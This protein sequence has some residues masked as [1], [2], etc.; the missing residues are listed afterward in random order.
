MST[1]TITIET[2]LPSHVLQL[3]ESNGARQACWDNLKVSKGLELLEESVF[4]LASAVRQPAAVN[5]SDLIFEN[6]R[7]QVN[8]RRI[9]TASGGGAV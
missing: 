6:R 9:F 2:L 8:L 3:A 7:K 1:L 4:E 5:A